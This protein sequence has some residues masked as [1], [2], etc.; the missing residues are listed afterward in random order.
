MKELLFQGDHLSEPL[1]A[2][3]ML[4]ESWPDDAE[5]GTLAAA[6]RA[7]LPARPSESWCDGET[8]VRC[9]EPC[10]DLFFKVEEGVVELE[11]RED[12]ESDTDE[13]DEASPRLDT[14]HVKLTCCS[15]H[16]IWK[17]WIIIFSA[18]YRGHF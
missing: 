14:Q 16:G 7:L 15:S 17:R 10:N 3:G 2:V 1:E 6:L 11:S 13:D 9:G 18:C 12:A 5:H 4:K 8:L